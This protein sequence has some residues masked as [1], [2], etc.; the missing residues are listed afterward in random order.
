MSVL[1]LTNFFSF[2]CNVLRSRGQSSGKGL[3]LFYPDLPDLLYLCTQ[4]NFTSFKAAD[5]FTSVTSESVSQK[6]INIT[7]CHTKHL[8]FSTEGFRQGIKKCAFA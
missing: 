1:R 7:F 3:P 5:L 6:L 4:A 8:L 2:W